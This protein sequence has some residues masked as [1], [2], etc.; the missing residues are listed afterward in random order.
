MSNW[1]GGAGAGG[2]AVGAKPPLQMS[3]DVSVLVSTDAA[4]GTGSDQAEGSQ[5]DGP[6]RHWPP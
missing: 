6:G 1:R 4:A 3:D 2:G 5:P